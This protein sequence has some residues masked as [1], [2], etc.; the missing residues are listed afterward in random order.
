MVY[1]VVMVGNDQD[2]MISV[3]VDYYEKEFSQ[4]EIAEKYK[5]SRVTV[6]NILKRSRLE[7]IVD[8]RVNKK[9]SLAFSLRTELQSCLKMER[10]VVCASDADETH[11]RILVGRAASDLLKSELHDELR[12]GISYG[13]TLYETVH[14]LLV[15]KHYRNTEVVQLLGALGSRDPKQDGFELARALSAKIGGV[16]RIIQAPLIVQNASLKDMLLAEPQ[17]A[18]AMK[19]ARSA[20]VAVLGVS[21]NRPEISGIVRAGF[22]SSEESANLYEDGAVGNVCGLHF[23]VHGQVLPI[24]LN[25]RTIAIAPD[26][27]RA[28][29]VRIAVACGV[30]K[31]DAILGAIRAGF[32]NA[33]VTD[34]DAAL[35]IM[36][37]IKSEE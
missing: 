31:A 32:A 9:P 37:L 12:I 5:I 14:Q 29:P 6:S 35:K 1:C 30:R 18:E 34:T 24:S 25:E 36:S 16:Y 8:I 15:R 20:G 27:L 19:I 10:I 13:T 17:I 22:L 21:S 28:I 4:Q 23:D 26:D 33:L 7:G 2:L 3:A 11:T